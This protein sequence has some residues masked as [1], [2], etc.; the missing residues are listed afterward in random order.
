MSKC[1]A[2]LGAQGIGKSTLANGLCALE[3]AKP[4]A[5]SAH[6]TRIG[7]FTF[8]DEDWTVLDCPGSL[9]FLQQ[10]MDAL[11]VA[12]IAVICVS[13]NPEHAVLSA[14]FIRLAEQ[15]GV[16]A[17]L[18]INRL[19]EALERARDIVAALQGYSTHPVVLRQIPMRQDGTIV[20]AV[21]LVSERAWKY[22]QGEHSEL[23]EI[24]EDLHDREAEARGAFL[25]N[26]SEYDD[27]LLE[28][29][30]EDRMPACD[31]VYNICTRVLR[32]ATVTPAFMGC[33][34]RGNG[35]FRLMKALR[36]ETP[37]PD[38]KA[39]A[40][41]GAAAV[42]FLARHRKHV[43]KTVYVRALRALSS[44]D[45]LGGGALGPMSVYGPG[46]AVQA[47]SAPAGSVVAAIKSDHLDGGAVLD[48]EAMP[49]PAWHRALPPLTRQGIV[50]ENDRDDAKLSEALHKVVAEDAS[51]LLEHDTETGAFVLAGQGAQHLRHARDVLVETFGVPTV[52]RE[53]TAPLRETMTKP[54]DVHY[55]HKKQS[56]G[57]GQF[58]DVKL[59]VAPTSRGDGFVFNETI[60][61][62]SVPKNYIPAVESGAREAT[63][64]GPLGF[65][66]VDIAVTLT[67]GQYHSVD[68]SDMAFKIAG[69]GGVRQALEEGGSVLLEPI[70]AVSF[71]V[72]SVF[73]GALNPLISS[74]RG[75]VLGFD[76]AA[77]GEGWDVLRAL[78]PGSVLAGLIG[79]VRSVTQGVGRFDVVFDHYQ[80]L[81]GRDADQLI[82]SRAR[83]LEDA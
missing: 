68:S 78:L 35:I 47:P 18:F 48:A 10:S 4:P 63:D 45:M 43:G 55:R 33:A 44:G 61:G 16:P 15:A 20:G 26:L 80:E 57:A 11:L 5:P 74:Q 51:L 72:P 40:L 75:Q 14:P 17:V 41:G 29:L 22:R 23:I 30:I 46:G 62:G 56:G 66:V 81:Y 54:A 60:H 49:A 19:D 37:G 76:R 3:G 21:D 31:V 77:D 42:S 25:E 8:L 27:W 83:A 50:A 34:S 53:V 58:A 67:D 59:T 52:E 1:I 28:E 70:Y 39:D 79:D 82:A 9:E 64:R 12:D 6:E 65:P 36:H 73:T 24:P 32:D 2:V 38:A 69:R 13:P 7:A 71:D